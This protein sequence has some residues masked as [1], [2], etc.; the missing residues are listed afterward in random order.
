[1][2]RRSLRPAGNPAALRSAMRASVVQQPSAVLARRGERGRPHASD[3]RRRRRGA[4]G[5]RGGSHRR[6]L[7]C[8]RSLLQLRRAPPA[9]SPHDLAFDGGRDLVIG[10]HVI[11]IE[12][13][14]RT[15]P[16]YF[17]PLASDICANSLL[18]GR[19]RRN[20]GRTTSRQGRADR[21]HG[22]ASRRNSNVATPA[23]RRHAR[24]GRHRERCIEPHDA[25]DLLTTN[26]RASA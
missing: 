9:S 5:S 6:S 24:R 23:Q 7:C 22:R 26:A 18:A 15:R 3:A 14:L 19:R 13:D 20:R 2:R 11:P 4:H 10:D 12:A 1:M 17:P 16:H 21:L 8:R 25:G